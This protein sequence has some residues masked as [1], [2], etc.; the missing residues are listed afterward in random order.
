MQFINT[1]NILIILLVLALIGVGFLYI[2]NKLKW[3]KKEKKIYKSTELSRNYRYYSLS[4]QVYISC[5]IM[6]V[7]IFNTIFL[8][9]RFVTG[10]NQ[11]SSYNSNVD[12]MFVVD[13][14][15]S[16]RVEDMDGASRLDATKKYLMDF[17]VEQNG[18]RMGLITYNH[19][20]SVE[21]PLT[22]DKEMVKVAIETISTIDELHAQG[23]SA[24]VGLEMANERIIIENDMYGANRSKVIIMVSD[25]EEVEADL[26]NL[27]KQL[28]ALVDNNV[29]VFVLGVGTDR[30]GNIPWFVSI[31]TGEQEYIYGSDGLAVSKLEE[32]ILKKIS[33]QTD[34][35]YMKIEDIGD[36]KKM[37]DK[38]AGEL[39]SVDDSAIVYN[40]TYYIFTSIDIILFLLVIMDLDKI[41]VKI[42]S[43]NK[44]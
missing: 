21:S 7:F 41:K 9:L 44:K 38:E 13:S 20:A 30:G 26:Q 11:S 24:A 27:D 14:S 12:I 42:R 39:S 19:K 8:L 18:H 29:K 43:K 35:K 6:L 16:M 32:E 34:G 1:K 5:V 10:V 25:G 3:L 33:E 31:Q 17:I 36:L 15:L 2:Y 28:K 37:V 4:S 23:S 40:E 22:T